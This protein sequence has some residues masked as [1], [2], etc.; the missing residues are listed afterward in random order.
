LLECG[1]TAAAAIQ[2]GLNDHSRVALSRLAIRGHQNIQIIFAYD[3][4]V[5]H[6]DVLEELSPRELER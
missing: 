4:K 3:D 5:R 2:G 1:Q 6:Y